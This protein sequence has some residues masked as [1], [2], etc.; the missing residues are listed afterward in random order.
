MRMNRIL[1][2]QNPNTS[3]LLMTL[4]D[5]GKLPSSEE[6]AAKLPKTDE[7][8]IENWVFGDTLP[9]LSILPE[10]AA[11]A[12][13]PHECLVMTW[14]SDTDPKNDAY[15]AEM[16]TALLKANGPSHNPFYGAKKSDG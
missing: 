8:T 7:Q 13:C 12:D 2:G 11:I 3:H 6:V 5:L 14:L 10:L 16:A 9:P 1:H 15:Y 4:R